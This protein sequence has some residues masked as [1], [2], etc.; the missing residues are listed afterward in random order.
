M[1]EENTNRRK[2]SVKKRTFD[3]KKRFIKYAR[4]RF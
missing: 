1:N 2:E 3:L 4:K